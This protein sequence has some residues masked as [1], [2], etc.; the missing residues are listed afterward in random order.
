[1]YAIPDLQRL[2]GKGYGKGYGQLPFD[3]KY[4]G[5]SY[6]GSGWRKPLGATLLGL[7][8]VGTAG[9][10]S[11]DPVSGIIGG[12]ILGS[13]GGLL[14]KGS[15][16]NRK[17]NPFDIHFRLQ[18][19][20][21]LARQQMGSG[22]LKNAR[23][24]V[25][26]KQVKNK[27]IGIRDIFGKHWKKKGQILIKAIK[28]AHRAQKGGNIFGDIGKLA[29]K[30]YKGLKS[31]RDKSIK[32][33]EQ[34]VAG[35]TKFKP[36]TL[37][38]VASGAVGLLGAASAFIPGIDLISV[39]AASAAALG[40]KSGAHL[41]KTSGRGLKLAG[42][43]RIKSIPVKHRKYL[44]KYPKVAQSIATI[45]HSGSGL[46]LAGS[47]KASRFAAALGIAGTSAGLG[48][49]AMYQWML[50]HPADAAKI[51]AQGTA[52]LASK[53]LSGQGTTLAGGAE[54][55]MPKGISYL[56]S[57]KIK[58]DRVSVYYGFYKKTSSGLTKAAF[59]KKGDKII[60]K[61][62]QA[63]GRRNVRYL[64]R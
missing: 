37:L 22:K 57:G 49:Y 43:G 23:L 44:L 20:R 1:M 14:M 24:K 62:R 18:M 47:G 13:I 63:L 6:R 40:L 38:N 33:L 2:A 5:M 3:G 8:A 39:P 41:L 58:R 34:F 55:K 21:A 64:N 61:K 51:A 27:P 4:Q 59:L 50:A 25:M 19:E 26:M 52:S 28:D 54:E 30:G 35:K 10:I 46:K 32:K 29:K 11:A 17:K 48:A 15:G 36:S 12:A 16:Y 7:A 9:A 42:Q 60:S 53:W 56:P 45:A 31:V